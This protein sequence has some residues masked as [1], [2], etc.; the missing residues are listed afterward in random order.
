MSLSTLFFMVI[1]VALLWEVR[2]GDVPIPTWT[3]TKVRTFFNWPPPM[4]TSSTTTTTS[5]NSDGTLSAQPQQPQPTFHIPVIGVLYNMESGTLKLMWATFQIC[6]SVSFSLNV[7]FPYP[8]D[9]F[10]NFLS[11]VM[12]DIPSVD[13]FE[14]GYFLR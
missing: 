2:S 12:L 9:A 4:P 5:L 10:S 14:G 7:V 3:P 8:Y 6:S 13:C 11:V 1:L